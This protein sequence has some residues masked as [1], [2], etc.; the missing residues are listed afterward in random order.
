MIR[1]MIIAFSM[2]S[3]IPIPRFE[4]KEEDMRYNLCFLPIIGALIGAVVYGCLYLCDM[5]TVPLM[6]RVC[7][8]SLIPILITGGFHIDGYMD[9][10]DAVNSYKPREEKLKILSDPHIGAFS[11]I[12]FAAYVLIWTGALTIIFDRDVSSIR[13]PLVFIFV[14]SRICTAISSLVLKK[15]KDDGMLKNETDK[16]GRSELLILTFELI[17]S[18]AVTVLFDVFAALAMT[19]VLVLLGL[20]YRHKTYKEFGGV[21]GDTAG[22]F[23]CAGEVLC[24]ITLAV[25]SL[26]IS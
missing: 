2:Y 15:A 16:A 6:A 7:V 13:I 18:I 4:W 9:V 24:L 10:M 20:Y 19:A 14:L 26:I 3:R 17:I 12:S 25:Y 21:T 1:S 5:L 23:V 8:V 22:C 11:M